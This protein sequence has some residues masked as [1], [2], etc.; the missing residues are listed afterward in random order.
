MK[1]LITS[2]CSFTSAHRTN[3]ERADDK[4]L[5]DDIKSWYYPHWLQA[6]FRDIKVYNM[7][8]PANNNSMIVR[9]A[10]YK[11]KELLNSGVEGKDIA[12]IIQW[13]SFFRRS[14]F[15]SNQIKDTIPLVDHRD[16]ANDYMKEKAEP[17]DNGYWIN[18]ALPDMRMSSLEKAEN[19]RLFKYNMAYIETLYNDES[20]YFE[21][22]EYFD[23][24]IQFCEKNDIQMKSFF[25]HNSFSLQYDYGLMPYNWKDANDMIDKLFNK[26]EII[27]TWG[28][29][30]TRV[31]IYPYCKYLYDSIDWNKYCWFFE[32]E[33]IHSK[34]GV[35]E[36]TIRNQIKSTDEDFNPIWMEYIDFG[37]QSAVEDALRNNKMGPTGHVSHCN[38]K[39]FTEEVI[40]KW[41][42]FQ[43]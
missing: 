5:S 1:Y 23:Y 12:M 24:L 29:E 33:G 37:S 27:N 36:W 17:G 21:W 28:E 25:M 35:F 43:K 2:G 20:R 32:E 39:K 41:D 38:Y 16:Y 6:K 18:L 14:H 15:I 8:S 31:D 19:Q 9:S 26:K 10:I 34:G 11:A 22:L 3:L 4:F 42:M 30:K 40:L 13:S 7:G